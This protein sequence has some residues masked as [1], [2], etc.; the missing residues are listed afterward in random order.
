MGHRNYDFDIETSRGFQAAQ[1]IVGTVGSAPFFII[2][3]GR[4]SIRELSHVLIT[5]VINTPVILWV[6]THRYRNHFRFLKS[7]FKERSRTVDNIFVLQSII[8]RQKFKGRPLYTCFVDLTKAF[9]YINRYALYYKLIMRGIHG[10]LL[11]IICSMYDK[12]VCRVKWKGVLGEQIDSKYGVLQGGM[13]SPKLFTE[14]LYDLKNY[15]ETKNG[16]LLDDTVMT[17]VL[18][19]R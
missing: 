16:V 17:Y 14:F 19:A 12:A 9:D 11:N 15:L 8:H 18:Y 3:T 13:L 10:K 2:L 4:W 1:C 5:G 7:G 6:I